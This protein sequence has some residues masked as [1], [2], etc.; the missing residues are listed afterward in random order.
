MT[1]GLGGSQRPRP[2]ADPPLR[3][4][5]GA[6]R[7]AC[8]TAIPIARSSIELS[9]LYW[10]VKDRCGQLC[11]PTRVGTPSPAARPCRRHRPT[12]S[13]WVR[14][15]RDRRSPKGRDEPHGGHL[16]IGV[17]P[18]SPTQQR[19]SAPFTDSESGLR[20]AC[21]V[22]SRVKLGVGIIAP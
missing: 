12:G 4:V 20:K 8:P 2:R 16:F 7:P 5:A 22:S 1:L 14:A 9:S 18:F 11:Q 13:L 6:G 17:A 15:Y 19:H 3:V 21:A 10:E